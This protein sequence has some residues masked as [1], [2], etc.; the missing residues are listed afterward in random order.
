MSEAID[1]FLEGEHTPAL[2]LGCTI[3]REEFPEFISY[4]L[5]LPGDSLSFAHYKQY[6]EVK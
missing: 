4:T 5:Y 6:K 3:T 1:K 2:H